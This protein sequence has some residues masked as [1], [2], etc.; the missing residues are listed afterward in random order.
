VESLTESKGSTERFLGKE[1]KLLR[2]GAV[3]SLKKM[4]GA[5]SHA[6]RRSETAED[7]AMELIARCAPD[8]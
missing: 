5:A 2:Y 6:R 1:E 8:V 3:G 7:Q 4:R